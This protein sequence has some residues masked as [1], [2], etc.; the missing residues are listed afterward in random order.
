MD[1][2][3]RIVR[4]GLQKI[5]H[6]VVAIV[7]MVQQKWLPSNRFKHRIRIVPY[8][9][10]AR[11]KGRIFQIRPRRLFVKMKE[12]LQIY[13]ALRAKNQR[14]VQLKGRDKPVDDIRMRV[15]CNF[16]AH[17]VPFAPLR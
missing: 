4:G 17:R 12:P 13:G 7:R 8:A 11:H 10:L 14:F 9:H 6:R 1:E 16:Q 5:H 3:P 15:G 2:H